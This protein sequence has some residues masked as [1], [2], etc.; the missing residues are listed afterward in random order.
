MNRDARKLIDYKKYISERLFEKEKQR[1]YKV[2]AP[3]DYI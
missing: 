2:V 3:A 1:K